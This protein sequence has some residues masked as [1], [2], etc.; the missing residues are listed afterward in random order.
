MKEKE[1]ASSARLSE[2][3]HRLRSAF[4]VGRSLLGFLVLIFL[5]GAMSSPLRM[6]LPVYVESELRRPPTFSSL[7]LIL[8]MG[9]GGVFALLGGALASHLGQ[10]RALLFGM[11]SVLLL[12]P[13][14]LIR[15]TEWLLLVALAA[16]L[17]D[18]LQVVGGQSYLVAGTPRAHLGLA[19]A[20]FFLG[21]TFGSSL[22]SLG[23]GAVVE[24][25][26]FAS[27]GPLGLAGALVLILSTARFLP[28]LR[29]G[30]Q[31]APLSPREMLRGYAPLC[32]RPGFAL[33]MVLRFLPTCFWG[34]ATLLMPLLL[35]RLSGSGPESVLKVS[36]YSA[37]SLAVAALCQLLTGRLSD[38]RGR[39]LPVLAISGLLPLCMLATALASHSFAALF[40]VGI[41]TTAVAW[42][43]SVNFPPLV[44][45]LTAEHEQSRGLGLLH[46]LWVMGML[47]G[48][49]AGGT[50][51]EIDPALPFALMA[52]LNLP[53]AVAGYAIW[54]RLGLSAAP[55][56]SG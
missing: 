39:G 45:E 56:V 11:A 16:G 31:P 55:A 43:M 37:A 42:S 49:W 17:L 41:V 35:Y 1:L 20:L 24:R 9:A 27:L 33:V 52:A 51:V 26:G 50:L 13:L 48:T 15:G 2:T 25:W 29:G 38:R 6:L 19:S 12:G 47:L 40:A 44:R 5:L 23:V 32:R 10:K 4:P 28:D 7:L 18:G 34:A 14:Y 8:M 53:T 46:L 21:S 36:T 22:G 54:R 3:V 30:G